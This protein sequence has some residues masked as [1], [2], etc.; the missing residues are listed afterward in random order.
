MGEAETGLREGE[1]EDC[2]AGGPAP[3]GPDAE[4]GEEGEDLPVIG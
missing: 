2:G 1:A 4:P 3:Q